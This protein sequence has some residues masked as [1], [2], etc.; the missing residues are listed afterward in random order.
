MNLY[1]YSTFF[2]GGINVLYLS[3]GKVV[4][5]PSWMHT[6]EYPARA[7]FSQQPNVFGVWEEILANTGKTSKNTMQIMS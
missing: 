7:N 2:P 3:L 5:Q 1:V 4:R 6:V